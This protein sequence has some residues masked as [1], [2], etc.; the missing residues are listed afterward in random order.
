MWIVGFGGGT[1]PSGWSGSNMNL[2]TRAWRHVG[3]LRLA[4]LVPLLCPP[5]L[6]KCGTYCRVVPP[7][8]VA[9]EA[10][11]TCCDTSGPTHDVAGGTC[12]DYSGVPV[13]GLKSSCCCPADGHAAAGSLPLR[14]S[15][16]S[17][18]CFAAAD[19]V[20]PGFRSALEA[21]SADVALTGYSPPSPGSQDTY[22]RIAN[23]RI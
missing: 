3:L 5:G 6:F 8:A 20:S 18:S 14:V 7:A 13:Q 22:L 4:V 19:T 21:S 1:L 2:V 12:H 11:S 15:G 23:L 10:A 9:P 17:Q 16:S